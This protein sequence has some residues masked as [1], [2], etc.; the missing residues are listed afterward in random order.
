MDDLITIVYKDEKSKF[1]AEHLNNMINNYSG[2]YKSCI[3]TKI[4][5]ETSKYLH[6]FMGTK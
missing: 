6:E 4:E 2:V 5:Y 1:M 3:K